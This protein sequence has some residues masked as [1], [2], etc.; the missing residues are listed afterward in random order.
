VTCGLDR[1][2]QIQGR[3]SPKDTKMKKIA[4]LMGLLIVVG[5]SQAFAVAVIDFGTGT[6]GPGGTINIVGTNANGSGIPID[7]LTILGA[8]INNGVFDVSGTFISA[9]AT[10]GNSGVLAFDTATNTISIT[11]G[12]PV[13]GVAPQVLLSG[14]F[15]SFTL[16][17][18]GVKGAIDAT[19]VDNKA[20]DLL[21]ALGLPI[22]TPFEL[23]GFSIGINTNGTGSPYTAVSTDMTNTAVPEPTALL[24]FGTGLAGL[25][26]IAVRRKNK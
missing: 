9:S 16:T 3:L 7:T 2:T 17:N 20:A 23:F 22:D 1:R 10:G 24:L 21:R 25:G 15:V 5:C 14:S 18:T 6:A 19:G 13:L 26:L 12:V 11:G 4:F 8:P